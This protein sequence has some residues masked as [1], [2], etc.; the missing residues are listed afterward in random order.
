MGLPQ[1]KSCCCGCSLSLG[2][3]LIGW[4]CLVGAVASMFVA[5]GGFVVL[6]HPD[7]KDNE[8]I[9]PF[10][11]ILKVIFWILIINA[12]ISL[13]FTVILLKGAYERK[14]KYV[15]LWVYFSIV[16]LIIDCVLKIGMLVSFSKFSNPFELL[17]IRKYLNIFYNFNSVSMQI[18]INI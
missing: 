3:K 8:K 18:C 6:D 10:I 13:V 2:T 4:L 5:W 11:P 17:S 15:K 12:A 9:Q 14:P 1:L 16:M 7:V